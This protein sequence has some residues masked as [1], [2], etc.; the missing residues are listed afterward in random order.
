M[1]Q[2]DVA[3][4]CI[5]DHIQ[6]GQGSPAGLVR[7]NAP[8]G[9]RRAVFAGEQRL[10][11]GTAAG[12]NQ[13]LPGGDAGGVAAGIGVGNGQEFALPGDLL[14]RG[15]HCDPNALLFELRRKTLAQ[16]P[17]HAGQQPVHRFHNGHLATKCAVGA[18]QLHAD[19][20]AADDDQRRRT[21]AFA[22][23]QVIAGADAGQL[24]AGNRR[25]GRGSPGGNDNI[26]RLVA[27]LTAL[28]GTFAGH[29][30]GAGNHRHT[31]GFH[32]LFH[33]AA[34]CV[35]RGTAAGQHGG[36]VKGQPFGVQAHCVGLLHLRPDFRRVQHGFGGNAAA[37]QAGAAQQVLFKQD[38]LQPG[39]GRSRRSGI[40]ARAAAD[41]CEIVSH[42]DASFSSDAGSKISPARSWATWRRTGVSAVLFNA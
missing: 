8:A 9:K 15:F 36:P 28:H 13:H 23:Q 4:L 32:Q 3:G 22:L 14:H 1:G 21:T 10:C 42:G 7:H 29:H 40:A 24:P 41:H 18:G 6:V 37:V 5:T 33:T 34:Q 27:D 12:G 30:C 35:H 31:A 39:L 38:H 16:F 20:A 26:S 11:V 19:D 2:L 17:V 25:Q